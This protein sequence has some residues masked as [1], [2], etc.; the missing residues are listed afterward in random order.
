MS[1]SFPN[2]L[3]AKKKRKGGAETQRETLDNY[4]NIWKINPNFKD[5]NNGFLN[6]KF[7]SFIALITFFIIS[8]YIISL[9][10]IVALII[11]LLTTILFIVAFE[12]KLSDFIK[13]YRHSKGWFRRFD[14]F[15]NLTFF[16]SEENPN[17]LFFTNKKDMIT[18]GVS[19][20]NVRIIPE[21]IHASLNQFIKALNELQVPFSYQILQTPLAN[22]PQNSLEES[23]Y[24]QKSESINS[25][26]TSIYFCTFYDVKGILSYNKLSGLI[27]KLTEYIETMR[28]N[29]SANFPH[30]KIKLLSE[31]ELIYAMRAVIMKNN[32]LDVPQSNDSF[33]PQ[34]IDSYDLLKIFFC[35]FILIYST[36]LTLSMGF[37]FIFT[38]FLNLTLAAIIFWL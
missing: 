34:K 36:F 26:K 20:F 11:G 12:N 8:T 15:E 14:P 22:S 18:V 25:Y 35:S 16:F 31:N 33:N 2:E 5:I 3:S 6:I 13:I 32:S 4:L 27:E 30:F 23:L 28:A 19:I 9:N 17:I 38:T 21:T 1:Y 7:I 29:F 10:L 24:Y 37:P